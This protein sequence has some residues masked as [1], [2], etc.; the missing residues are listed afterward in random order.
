M[1]EAEIIAKNKAILLKYM[2]AEAVDDVFDYLYSNKIHFKIVND[3][4]TKLGDYRWPQHR[5]RYHQIT[6]NGGLNS[7]AFLFVLLHEMAH[8]ATYLRYQTSVNP[9][10]HEWQ[11]QYQTMLFHYVDKHIFPADIE[12]MIYRC[13]SSIPF[14]AV[15]ERMMMDS[16]RRYDGDYDSMPTTLLQDLPINTIFRTE[17]GRM[18]RSIEKRRTR[19]KCQSIPDGTLYLVQGTA[20]VSIVDDL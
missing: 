15:D 19:Y 18:F 2:P 3:R 4:K 8:H 11:L 10:G 1:T 12:Q 16:F 9:H 14:K 13:Y 6:I 20:R 17:G 7:Y 5:Y